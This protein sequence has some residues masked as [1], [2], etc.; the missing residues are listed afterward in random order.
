MAFNRDTVD[1][2]SSEYNVNEIIEND[3]SNNT[4]FV[5]IDKTFTLSFNDAVD[6]ETISVFTNN[7]DIETSERGKRGSVQL[8][9]IGDVGLGSDADSLNLRMKKQ[10]TVPPFILSSDTG[11]VKDQNATIEV[12]MLNAPIISNANASFSFSPVVNLASNST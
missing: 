1:S 12:E 6:T 8:S 11:L 4:I 10:T 7:T 3:F 5:P 2:S 9:C